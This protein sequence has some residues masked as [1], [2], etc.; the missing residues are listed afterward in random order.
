MVT[1]YIISA[2]LERYTFMD[3]LLGCAG[4]LQ[5]AENMVI[6]MPCK[7]DVAAW[8]A[9]FALAEIVVIWRWQMAFPNEFLKWSL[10]M[11]LGMCCCQTSMLVLATGFSVRTLSTEKGKKI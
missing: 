11:L 8:V 9:C 1:E 10:T 7:L 4:H 2:K 3:D 5:E 6:T